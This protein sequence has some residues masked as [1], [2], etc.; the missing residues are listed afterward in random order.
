MS[1]KFSSKNDLSSIIEEIHFEAH[2]LRIDAFGRILPNAG[3]V[4]VFC[5]YDDEYELLVQIKDE[6]TES[7]ESP[8][9]KYFKLKKPIIIPKKD[10]IPQTMYTYLYIRRPDPTLYG[11]HTGDIDFYLSDDEFA[12]LVTEMKNGKT[13]KPARLYDQSG[14][15]MIELSNPESSVLAYV[16][17]E[18]MTKKVR[19]KF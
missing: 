5:H 17:T 18:T 8:V 15:P 4:G 9:Q 10:S 2:K 11:K 1:R 7:P 14:E 6:L 19:T 12:K 3:N 16:S 13:L